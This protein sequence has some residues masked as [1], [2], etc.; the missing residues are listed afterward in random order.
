VTGASAAAT[1]AYGYNQADQM[2]AATMSSANAL[3]ATTARAADREDDRGVTA[4]LTW[5]GSSGLPLLLSDGTNGY[6]YGPNG[7]P[8]EQVNIPSGTN[9]Y[10][11]SDDQGSTRALLGASGRVVATFS[12]DPYGNLTA[13]TGAASTSLLYDGQYLDPTTGFYHLR[14]R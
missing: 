13:T 11:V 5:D 14:A 3:T 8:V 6:L 12:F 9:V 2:T 4:T 1:S 7:T 10:F